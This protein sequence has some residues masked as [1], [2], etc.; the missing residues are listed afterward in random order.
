MTVQALRLP[1]NATFWESFWHY[2][3]GIPLQAIQRWFAIFLITTGTLYGSTMFNMQHGVFPVWVAVPLAVGTEWTYLSGLAYAT[4]MRNGKWSGWM[5]VAGALTSGL[6]GV[7]YIL[8]HY[9]VIPAQPDPAGALVL[10]LAHVAPLIMLLLLYTLCK[11]DYTT[12]QREQADRQR[13]REEHWRDEKLLIEIEKEKI[14]LDR[15]RLSLT[16]QQVK[17]KTYACPTCGVAL[18]Q[19]QAAIASRYGYCRTCKPTA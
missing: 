17:A 8:G 6:Y 2:S 1:N 9:G 18:T 3:V 15:E 14:A 5:I 19:Q 12:E 11:R 4:E 7:L 10:A 16:Q 13:E